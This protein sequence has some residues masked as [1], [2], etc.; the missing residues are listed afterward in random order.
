M[1]LKLFEEYLVKGQDK[2]ILLLTPPFDKTPLNPGYIK[3]YPPG[4]QG[5]WRTIY[6]WVLMGAAGLGNERRRR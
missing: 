2:I 1:P 5:K 3:G 4:V 6:P